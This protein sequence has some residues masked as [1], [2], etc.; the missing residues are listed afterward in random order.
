MNGKDILKN[1]K[2]SSKIFMIMYFICIV[3]V[4]LTFLYGAYK[5]D[6][7]TN[8][9]VDFTENGAIDLEVGKYVYMRVDGLSDLIATYGTSDSEYS[10]E[11]D[12]YYIAIKDG[13]WYIVNLDNTTLNELKDIQAYTL[14]QTETPPESVTIYGTTEDVPQELRQI[15]VDVYNEGLTEEE[16]VSIDEF[17][18]CYGS[19]LLNARKTP[20]DLTIETMIIF[21]AFILFIAFVIAHI[22]DK[23]TRNRIYKYLKKN[24]Y[25]EDLIQ[26]LDDNVEENFF[27][28]K[29]IFTKDFFVDTYKSGFCAVKY[30][31][32]KWIHPHTIKYNGIIVSNCITLHLKDGKTNIQ[33]LNVR[34]KIKPEFEK[35]FAKICDKIPQD[36]LKGYTKE[37][38]KEFKNYKRDL[39]NKVI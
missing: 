21:I 29:V 11:N 14:G 22:C 5:I 12:K 26:Q 20:G 30:S 3:T 15:A 31:D 32:I 34:G 38:I 8:E 23:I 25:E 36:S 9:A 28:D 19:V 17:E 24:E 37:N 7:E 6:K 4:V 27:G 1:G 16:K 13:Y 39:Q 2:H 10:D 18:Q 33:C 35:V